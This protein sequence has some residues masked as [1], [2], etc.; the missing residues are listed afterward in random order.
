VNGSGEFY[1][2]ADNVKKLA[3]DAEKVLAGLDVDAFGKN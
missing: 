2:L 3:S 1:V